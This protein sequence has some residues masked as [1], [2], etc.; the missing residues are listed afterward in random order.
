M[1]KKGVRKQLDVKRKKTPSEFK[2][3]CRRT[4]LFLLAAPQPM[5][6]SACMFG[7]RHPA[8]GGTGMCRTDHDGAPACLCDAGFASRDALGHASCVP[9]G[10][11]VTGYLVLAAL[12]MLMLVLYG[13]HL[14]EY[15]H[16]S[17]GERRSRRTATR[18]SV[19]LCGRYGMLSTYFSHL[20]HKSVGILP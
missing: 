8:W 15:R 16:L 19:I 10:V 5:E 9:Y 14:A 18:L 4:C 7:C 20:S 12:S 1:Q 2:A 13:R 6:S 17:D 3:S 11:L